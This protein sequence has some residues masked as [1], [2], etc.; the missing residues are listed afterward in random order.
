VP[1]AI[2]EVNAYQKS[3]EVLIKKYGTITAEHFKTQADNLVNLLEQQQAGNNTNPH[4]P[5]NRPMQNTAAA[6]LVN[7]EKEFTYRIGQVDKKYKQ[8]GRELT[9]RRKAHEA[10]F[11]K[12]IQDF[13]EQQREYAINHEGASQAISREECKAKNDLFNRYQLAYVDTAEKIIDQYYQVWVDHINDISFWL[14]LGA[15]TKTQYKELFARYAATFLARMSGLAG[16]SL[17]AFRYCDKDPLAGASSD[18][19]IKEPECPINLEFAL[20]VGKINIDCEV[21]ELE[22]GEFALFGF[23]KNFKTG[24]TTIAF[25]A[26]VSK[27]LFELDFGTPT[28]PEIPY[29]P[30]ELGAKQQFYITFDRDNSISDIG[31]LWEAEA[32]VKGMNKPDAKVNM[33]LGMLSGTLEIDEGPLKPIADKIFGIQAETQ[34][35]NKIPIYKTD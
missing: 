31:V 19:D 21:F 26:G 28:N 4:I 23:E 2:S 27:G 34:L 29:A 18:M 9:V 33:K 1:R 25:G 8:L 20:V 24:T 17:P 12:I 5:K 22:L 35:N 15:I 7:L 11:Q 16:N 10:E 13:A 30:L 3:A 32:D 14:Y 6:I